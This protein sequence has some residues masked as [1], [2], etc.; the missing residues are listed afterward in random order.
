MTVS[1]LR[2]LVATFFGAGRWPWG[3][4]TAGTLATLPFV[5][6]LWWYGTW[7]IHAAAA[8]AAI[9]I[10]LWASRDAPRLFGAK[11]PGCIVIDEVA[12]TLI[13]TLAVPPS[14]L[15]L[16]AAFALFRAA[17]I[18]K[19]WPCDR[20]QSLPGAWG[21]MVDDLVAGLYVNLALRAGCFLGD[22]WL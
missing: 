19:P 17:D 7:P 10:G 15:A 2:P 14:A 22:Q 18:A 3:P 4:G 20:L 13:A 8:L 5:A 9:V 11:D 16:V 1:R 6:G 21:I 12:G